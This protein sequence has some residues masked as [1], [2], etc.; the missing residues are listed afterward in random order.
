MLRRTENCWCSDK[1]AGNA[2]QCSRAMAED[3]YSS[4]RHLLQGLIAPCTYTKG[5]ENHQ[6]RCSHK[7][8]P[9]DVYGSLFITEKSRNIPITF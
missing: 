3:S 1:A 4:N 7:N 8:L 6:S 2:N 9:V 5:K